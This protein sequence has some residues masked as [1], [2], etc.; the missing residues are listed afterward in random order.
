MD[1]LNDGRSLFTQRLSQIVDRRFAV[2]VIPVAAVRNVA[3]DGRLAGFPI[4]KDFRFGNRFRCS[5]FWWAGGGELLGVGL[6]GLTTKNHG[7]VSSDDC[8]LKTENTLAGDRFG[9]YL[10]A[11]LEQFSQFGKQ[12][13][14]LLE[15]LGNRRLNF[16]RLQILGKLLPGKEALYLRPEILAGFPGGSFGDL[17]REYRQSTRDVFGCEEVHEPSIGQ[18]MRGQN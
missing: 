16:F 10:S 18:G 1:R 17:G 8:S 12:R 5:C 15:L 11:C 3:G 4:G 13:R 14:A 6:R 2:L 7:E 9:N